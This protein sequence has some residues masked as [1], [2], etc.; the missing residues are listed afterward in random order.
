MSNEDLTNVYVDKL[1]ASHNRLYTYI[2]SLT[3]KPDQAEDI[4]QET[5]KKLWQ[6]KDEYDHSREFLPWAYTVAYNQVRAA[7][8]KVKRERL[9]FQDEEVLHA[10]AN[11]QISRAEKVNERSLALEKCMASLSEK[12]KKLIKKYYTDGFTMEEVGQACQRSASSI[13]VALHR[14]RVSLL[15]CIK[16]QLT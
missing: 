9:V 3:G 4:L 1:M 6:L 7:R 15:E 8:T 2:Y 14:I 16:E 11:E 13:A 10:L 12:H 5:N